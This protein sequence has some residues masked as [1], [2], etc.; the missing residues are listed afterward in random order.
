MHFHGITVPTSTENRNELEREFT[1]CILH[2]VDTNLDEWVE[3]LESIIILQ[4]SVMIM[5]G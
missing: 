1:K 5:I 3:E 4:V 2:S